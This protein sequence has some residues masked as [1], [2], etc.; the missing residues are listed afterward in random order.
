MDFD[1]IMIL[2]ATLIL[3]GQKENKWMMCSIPLKKV[4]V[5]AQTNVFI[6]HPFMLCIHCSKV[7][8]HWKLLFIFQEN[9]NFKKVVAEG[10]L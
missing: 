10:F 8:V 9:E 6:L 3:G 2:R 7:S 1:K 5:N 4:A